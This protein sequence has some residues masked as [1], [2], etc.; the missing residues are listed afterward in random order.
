MSNDAPALHRLASSGYVASTQRAQCSNCANHRPPFEKTATRGPFCLP[1]QAT[2]S[3][4]GW[5]PQHLPQAGSSA[6]KEGMR[7]RGAGCRDPQW[8]VMI[9]AAAA[10]PNGLSNADVRALLSVDA[11]F[12]GTKLARMAGRGALHPAKPSGLFTR[13]FATAAAAAAWLQRHG[14]QLVA[15]SKHYNPQRRQ[16]GM[17]PT[18]TGVDHNPPLRG[19]ARPHPK[20]IHT[21][22][23]T[24]D[25]VHPYQKISLPPDPRYPSFAS[26]QPGIDPCT[27]GPW[28]Q[29]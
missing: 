2:I 14:N 27:G 12:A 11:H 20:M 3:R 8:P 23:P 1:L 9:A 28:G 22:V 21:I 16:P 13:W 5:C 29:Q 4:L 15:A 7:W 18:V 19:E 17:P 24:P 6:G 10:S 26:V 25:C